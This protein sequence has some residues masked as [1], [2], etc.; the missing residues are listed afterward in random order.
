[1]AAPAPVLLFEFATK[2][3]CLS[4]RCAVQV[5]GMIYKEHG[6]GGL[7][8]GLVPRMCLGIWQTLFMVTG[9]KLVIELVQEYDQ[10]A[11]QG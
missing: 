1:M 6:I 2:T 9:A 8:K 3:Q 4:K 5:L 7:F 11:A 10:A